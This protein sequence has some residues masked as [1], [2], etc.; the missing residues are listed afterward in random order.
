MIVAKMPGADAGRSYAGSGFPGLPED[1]MTI[2]F[3]RNTALSGMILTFVTWDHPLIRGGID[4]ILGSKWLTSVATKKQDTA[5]RR[6]VLGG[7][8]V[9]RQPGH[10]QLYRFLLNADPLAA[11]QER[12]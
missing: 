9:T 12:Q 10:P 4:L 2:T 7:D 5:C 6:A 11:G 8:L 3:E 1:G